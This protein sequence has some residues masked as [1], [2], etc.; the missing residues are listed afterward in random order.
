MRESRPDAIL[1]FM[2]P[3]TSIAVC[4]RWAAGT[5]PRLVLADHT[6]LTEHYSIV[7]P[8]R[9]LKASMRTTYPFADSRVAVSRAIARDAARLA[10]LGFGD[11]QIIP[12]P[13][14]APSDLTKL[15]LTDGWRGPP[16]ARFLW[17]GTFKA[18]KRPL[19]TIAAFA[20]LDLSTARLVMVGDGDLRQTA[21]RYAESLGMRDRVIFSGQC[22][23]ERFYR[24]ADVFVASSAVD[25]LPMVLIEA[26]AYGLRIVSTATSGA[27]EVL[28]GGE[29]GLLV[30]P[31]DVD[32]LAAA[33][34][35]AASKDANPIHQRVRARNYEPGPIFEAY[36]KILI[37]QD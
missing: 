12:N 9:F 33:M 5:R 18:E 29:Y 27:K 30:E 10:N 17:V 1:A 4:A 35:E 11:F 21:A 31:G 28:A 15:D 14:S 22:N 7:S 2:W 37:P 26:L 36:E 16:G 6:V 32:A 8:A 20:K 24:S 19:E 3:L 23:P 25:G 34:A 13:V